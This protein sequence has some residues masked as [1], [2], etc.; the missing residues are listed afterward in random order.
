MKILHITNWFPNN[1]N[2]KESIWIKNQI[3][4]LPANFHSE[5]IHFKILTSKRIKILTTRNTR[6]TQKL[7]ELPFEKWLVWEIIYGL[8]LAY[9]L[10]FKKIHKEIDV[11][12]F[13]IAY[14]MLTYWHWV[15]RWVKKPIVITEH[16]SAY[17]FN[18]GVKKELPRIQRIFRQSIPVITVSEVLARDIQQF[19]KT[20]FPSYILPNVVNDQIFF[21]DSSIEKEPFL[22]MVSQWKSPKTP[23]LVMKA[24]LESEVSKKYSL[25]I[26]GYG[27][28]WEEI[29]AF[30]DTHQSKDKIHLIGVLD[31]QQI[32]DNLQRCTAFLHPSDYETF[33]VVCAEAVAC[34]A[35][36]IAPNIGGIPEVVGKNGHLMGENN[37]D[38]WKFAINSIPTTFK[39]SYDGRF[40][41][42]TVGKN[43]ERVLNEVIRNYQKT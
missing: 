7:L 18:F 30:V 37:L 12:N 25:K 21:A 13:H 5:I 33:S 34:G 23:I 36:V 43:Y 19:A 41:P 1:L 29:N 28:Q 11:I 16:W 35:F 4:S 14:P 15:K 38:N 8:W 3:D 24:F 20:K 17:H 26:G 2:K 6:L 31:S 10:I 42:K 40:S 22:F 27:P 9:Q 39:S 32:A